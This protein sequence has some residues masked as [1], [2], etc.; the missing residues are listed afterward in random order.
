MLTAAAV[1]RPA[2]EVG[3]DLRAAAESGWGFS[4]RWC[5]DPLRLASIQTTKLLPIDLNS[6]LWSLERAIHTACLQTG[7]SVGAEAFAQRALQRQAAIQRWL[8]HEAQGHHVDFHWAAQRPE[9]ALTGAA[10]VP[11]YVGLAS[12]EQARRTAAALEAQLL[13]A[14]GVLATTTVS[15]QQWDAPNGWAPLQWLAVVGLRRYGHHAL[16]QTIAARWLAMVARVH[17]QTGKVMEK[18]DVCEERAGGGGEYPTQ[19]GF[20][21]TSGVVVA[22]AAL[23]P[24]LLP[25]DRE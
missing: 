15:G 11:L 5:A 14:H 1:S 19:D 22:L 20:G 8:W 12:A 3:R 2:A 9:L 10:L 16:A 6:L 7:D 24:E 21:W 4:S 25:A 13:R 23:Y 18:Y 17:R